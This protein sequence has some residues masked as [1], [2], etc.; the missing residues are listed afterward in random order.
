MPQLHFPA[1]PWEREGRWVLLALSVCPA[2]GHSA[3]TRGLLTN[4]T[5]PAAPW[6]P[7]CLTTDPPGNS[8]GADLDSLIWI[9]TPPGL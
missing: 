1:S 6:D 2:E 9:V 4:P 5:S 3:I 8:L 7:L